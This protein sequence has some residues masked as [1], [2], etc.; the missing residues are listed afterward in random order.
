MKI[1]KLT[2]HE[3]YFIFVFF[4][5]IILRRSKKKK[6]YAFEFTIFPSPAY[7]ETEEQKNIL[8]EY[9][10]CSREISLQNG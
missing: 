10:F 5:I 4:L 6:M 3:R 9:L 2:S 7:A 1:F 8:E